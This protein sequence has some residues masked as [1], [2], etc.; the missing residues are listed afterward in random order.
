MIERTKLLRT[1]RLIQHYAHLDYALGEGICCMTCTWAT[2]ANEYSTQSH[3]IWVKWY[4][5]GMNRK[6]WKDM[7]EVWIAHNLTSEQMRVVLDLLKKNGFKPQWHGNMDDCILL[8]GK[9]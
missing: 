9:E 5:H 3:G 4:R 1:L 8:R 6:V 7:Q 2:I